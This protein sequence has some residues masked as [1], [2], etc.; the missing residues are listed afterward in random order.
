MKFIC[1]KCAWN[2]AGIDQRGQGLLFLDH[3]CRMVNDVIF[4]LYALVVFIENISE[5]L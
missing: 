5:H 2:V 4:R 3:A 1:C